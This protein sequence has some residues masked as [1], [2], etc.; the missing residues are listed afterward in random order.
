MNRAEALEQLESRRFDLAVIGGGINGAAVAREAALRGLAVAL[1]DRGDFAAAT[2]SRSTKLIHGGL[3]YLPQGHLAM[4]WTSLRERELM[5]RL[6]A[7]HLVKTR[8]FLLPAYRG[9]TP[10]LLKLRMGLS[11]YDLMARLPRAQRHRTLSRAAVLESE[12]ALSPRDL[13][14]AVSYLDGWSDDARL[15]IENLVDAASEGAAV[16]NYVAVES[17]AGLRGRLAAAGARDLE[18][19]RTFELRARLFVNAAGPWVDDVR[20]LAGPGTSAPSVRLTKGVHIVIPS[21]VLPLRNPLVLSD[22]QGRLVFAIP[23]EGYVLVGTTDTDFSGDRQHVCADESDIA[24]LLE[25][26]S[27]NL[28]SS[29]PPASAVAFSFAGLRALV[30]KAQRRK[31][32]S[33]VSREEVVIHGP[34]GLI[35]VAGGKMTTHRA[36]AV[37]VVELAMRELGMKPGSSPSLSRPLPGAQMTPADPSEAPDSAWTLDAVQQPYRSYLCARYGS[38]AVI[39]AALAADRP[40]LAAPLAPG[41][42]A[43]GAEV[44]YAVR[45]EMARQLDD[46]LMRRSGLGWRYPREA[47]AAASAAA[48]LMADELAWSAA[49]E[50]YQQKRVAAYY[51]APLIAAEV[52]EVESEAKA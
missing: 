34:M 19:Q 6:T 7:P 13:R 29:P 45:Y 46:F 30:D 38:R 37:R 17:L 16:A 25:T 24:Y 33:T 52:P 47:R 27:L 35:S 42:P 50:R 8:R 51:D 18:T 43:V 1:V 41:S 22:G 32:P 14:G 44:L 28:A 12:P 2:S 20:R 5:R 21:E 23:M 40:E 15:T 39:V 49:E 48:R 10:G 4:V 31:S 36:I 26:L 3:R 9:R 11:L